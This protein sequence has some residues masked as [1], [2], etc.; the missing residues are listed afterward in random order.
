MLCEDYCCSTSLISSSLC[1]VMVSYVFQVR[2]GSEKINV[3]F[4]IDS[5]RLALRALLTVNAD[6][7]N[8]C[9]FSISTFRF[10]EHFCLYVCLDFIGQVN[11][12]L[13]MEHLF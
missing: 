2:F 1:C 12:L 9:C 3:F 11:G 10:Y 8:V 7:N 5:R 4:M 6:A 13:L